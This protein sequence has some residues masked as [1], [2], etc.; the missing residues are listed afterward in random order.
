[1]RH[2][3]TETRPGSVGSGG[4]D[5]RNVRSEQD[6]ERVGDLCQREVDGRRD[7]RNRLPR[8]SSR[9]RRDRLDAR[10]HDESRQASLCVSRLYAGRRV[11]IPGPGG[12]RFRRFRLGDGKLHRVDGSESDGRKLRRFGENGDAKPRGVGTCDA[13]A[14]GGFDGAVR[15]GSDDFEFETFLLRYAEIDGDGSDGQKPRSRNDLLRS[16]PRDQRRRRFGLVRHGGTETRLGSGGSDERNLY[17]NE[18]YERG[19]H[20]GQREVDGRRDG[21]N[22]LPRRS[23]RSRRDR[24]DARRHDESRQASLC[25]SRLYAG[26]RVRIPGPGGKRFRRFRLG[27]G[28]LHRVDGSE[29][30]GRKLRRFGENGD[31][32]PRGVG[33]CDAN[34]RGGFDGAVRDGS[35]DFEFE[36]FL[37]RYVEVVDGDADDQKP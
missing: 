2:G 4:S 5:E 15:V 25:V 31:A 6:F 23:S 9:S 34:A 36:T 19:R 28:K 11:R 3:G 27:D 26:R 30:D 16:R 29:S 10:R 8:R 13:N 37:L 35:D 20:G 18:A 21:R 7:G 33:T 24:L 22:R 14:R 12:K 1:M 32:K 17:A